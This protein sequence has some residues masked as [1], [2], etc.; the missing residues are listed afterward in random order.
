MALIRPECFP[1]GAQNAYRMANATE[2]VLRFDTVVAVAA[3]LMSTVAAGASVYQTRV[4]EEQF[5]AANWP[6]LSVENNRT[7][8]SFSISVANDGAGPALIRSAQFVLDGKP[9]ASWSPLL[10]LAIRDAAIRH[11]TVGFTGDS[12]SI[13]AS[14]TIRPG[15]MRTLIAVRRA[16]PRIITAIRSHRMVLN[17]CYC[18]LN[19]RCWQLADHVGAIAPDLPQAVRACEIGSAIEPLNI[20]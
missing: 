18:S 14:V 15:D 9:A 6:Y 20:K 12:S 17:F 19:D 8:T 7:T 4:I 16:P 13:D 10:E 1:P 3:L 2:R 11:G 5:A